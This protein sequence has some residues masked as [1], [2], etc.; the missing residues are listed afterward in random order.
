MP[1]LRKLV[2]AGLSIAAVAACSS[3]PQAD[4]AWVGSVKTLETPSAA[5]SPSA[6]KP[7]AAAAV[8][9]TY[10]FP[11]VGKSSYAHTHHDYQATDVMTA[12]GNRFVAVTGGVVLAVSKKDTWSP[13]VN[14]GA[15]RGGLSVSILGDDGVR[16]YGSHLSS[17][18][19]AI[20]PGVRVKS[21]QTLGKTGDTGDASACH[22]HFGISPPCAKTGDWWNQRG[23][24]YPWPYLDSWRTK[25]QKS[26]VAAVKAWQQKHGCPSKPT[27]DK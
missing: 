24:L 1:S 5:P 19:K 15:T 25:G 2:L 6:V 23:T 14:A 10:T 4:P 16:Y 22:L 11:V 20:N 17:V 12:C 27:V 13:K 9:I 26:P 21:G 3:S 8:K 18:D 7:K